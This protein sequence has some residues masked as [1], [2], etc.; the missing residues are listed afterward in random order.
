MAFGKTVVVKGAVSKGRLDPGK[1]TIDAIGCRLGLR[2]D[3]ADTVAG[4]HDTAS[5][6]SI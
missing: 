4:R 3:H 5:R 6:E 1:G 2:V